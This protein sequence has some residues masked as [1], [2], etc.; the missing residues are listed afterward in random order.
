MGEPMGIFRG[1]GYIVMTAGAKKDQLQLT[2]PILTFSN[3]VS[4]RLRGNSHFG[5]PGIGGHLG[6]LNL[7]PPTLRTHT[8]TW[9][10]THGRYK[11]GPNSEVRR[12]FSAPTRLLCQD[13]IIMLCGCRYQVTFWRMMRGKETEQLTG[14]KKTESDSI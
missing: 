10:N 14:E 11:R 4:R 13:R 12:K 8:H 7:I 3:R 9:E 2:V 5:T 1:S 6:F